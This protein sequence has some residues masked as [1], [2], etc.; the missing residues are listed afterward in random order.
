MKTA[1]SLLGLFLICLA[2]N[3][4]ARLRKIKTRVESVPSWLTSDIQGFLAKT[5]I[6]DLP[7]KL[8]RLVREVGDNNHWCCAIDTVK[9]LVTSH[10]VIKYYQTSHHTKYYRGCGWWGWS[11]CSV[12]QT[13]YRHN[14][15]YFTQYKSTTHQTTCPDRHSVCC[16]GYLL[17][18][19]HCLP[20]HQL[21]AIKDDLV[22]LKEMGLLAQVQKIG[23]SVGSKVKGVFLVYKGRYTFTYDQAVAACKNVGAK[24]ATL[25]ELNYAWLAGMDQCSCGWTTDGKAHYPITKSL[26]YGCGGHYPGVRT[27]SWQST[28]DA[29][30]SDNYSPSYS[31]WQYTPWNERGGGNAVYLDRHIMQCG[32]NTAI[33][34]FHLERGAGDKIRYKYRCRSVPANSCNFVQK[35]TP[36]NDDG[37][38]NYVYHDRHA[39]NCGNKGFMTYIHL[40][41]DHS[42]KNIRFDYHCCNSKRVT[43]CYT[44]HTGY[45][46]DGGGKVEF[47]DRQTVDCK[48]DHYL[49]YFHLNRNSA[50]DRIRYT[51]TCCR[52]H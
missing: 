33:S 24:L 26:N 30:C 14:A 13:H 48:A 32:G 23:Y 27:C 20:L 40:R 15:G 44:G 19:E 7:E 1:I 11:R 47:L 5:K 28:W 34:Y 9:T 43:S 29:Y 38:G 39:P 45:T 37:G 12:R 21:A 10:A 18:A 50:G 36:F 8:Q 51:Y 2:Q 46:V 16:R 31:G 3:G 4:D 17:V 6:A 25:S 42:G 22:K 52:V 49:S 41:R 35:H